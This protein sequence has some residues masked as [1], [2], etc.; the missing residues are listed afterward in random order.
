MPAALEQV[1]VLDL[2]DDRA[3]YAGKLLGDLGAQV[4]RLEPPDGD[5]LRRRGPHMNGQLDGESLWHAFFASSR[6]HAR[7]DSDAETIPALAQHAAIVIDCGRLKAAGIAHDDL[8]SANP[9]LVIVDV[10][11]FGPD[12]PWADYQA[13]A[14]VAEA[15]GGVAATSGDSDTPPLKLFGDQYAFVAGVYA[16]IAA[17]SA[18]HHARA[19]GEGQ[20]VQLA[21]HETLASVLEHVLMWAWYDDALPFG[22]SAAGPYLPRQGS[23]HW[24]RA[25]QVMQARGGSIMITPT[26]DFQKQLVW[27]VEEDA[28]ADLLDPKYTEPENLV[29]LIENSMNALRAWVAEKD[30]EPSSTKRSAAT[31]RSAG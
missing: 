5:P 18:L 19:S 17:L 29:L 2:S 6:S 16:A 31:I 1:R 30:V 11:S 20:V 27:L 4:L 21:V 9:A 3:I 14:I 24:S 25:Y 13:P 12:G 7:S 22:A 26:P 15:L 28:H 8:L 10:S 23:L